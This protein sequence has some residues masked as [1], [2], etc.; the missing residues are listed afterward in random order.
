MD[1]EGG[2]YDWL[3]SLSQ[4]Q[5]NRFK[6]ITIEFHGIND[7][8]WGSSYEKKLRCFINL[9]QTHYLIHIHGN[10]Y[11]GCQ[12]GIPDVVELTYINKNYFDKQPELN[13]TILPIKNLDTPNSLC[14]KDHC[15]NMKPFV[16]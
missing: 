12:N 6:Q 16:N 4:D 13:K 9:T 14:Y 7:D 8:T 2:E 11:G 15:L 10:N 3:L 1:I 5:L